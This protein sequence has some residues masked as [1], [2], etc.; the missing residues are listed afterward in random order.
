MTAVLTYTEGRE[1]GRGEGEKGKE[2]DG[3]ERER[4][5]QRE[6][7]VRERVDRREKGGRSEIER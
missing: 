2:G 1:G 6:R 5:Y 7:E 4:E 3:R